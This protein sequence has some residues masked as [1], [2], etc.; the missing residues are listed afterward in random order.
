MG[1]IVLCR[2][3]ARGL[4]LFRLLHRELKT[5]VCPRFPPDFRRFP[6]G[7]HCVSGHVPGQGVAA[8]ARRIVASC[9]ACPLGRTVPVT[10]KW[11]VSIQAV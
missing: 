3:I 11:S 4:G 2:A 7:Q 6:H 5:V 10:F 1:H 9:G 8:I